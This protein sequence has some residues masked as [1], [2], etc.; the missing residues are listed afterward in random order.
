MANSAFKK[1]VKASIQ[2]INNGIADGESIIEFSIN[3]SELIRSRKTNWQFHEAPGTIGSS[4]SFINVSDE[5]IEM[6]LML[7]SRRVGAPEYSDRLGILPDLAEIESWGL[8]DLPL[9]HE[10]SSLF[11]SP[12]RIILTFGPRSWF[13]VLEEVKIQ[14]IQHDLELKPTVARV[15]ITLRSSHAT[16]AELRGKMFEL[17]RVVGVGK[18]KH[19]DPG[20]VFP[21][22]RL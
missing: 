16:L 9:F 8:P 1:P 6:E 22:R 7:S 17:M 19:R 4:P 10:D 2:K 13:C 5:I 14:E 15:K 18:G 11:V 20:L 12:P 3:P 21:P